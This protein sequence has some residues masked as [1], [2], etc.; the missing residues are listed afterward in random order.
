MNGG[1]PL[2]RALAKWLE[3]ALRGRETHRERA[4][5]R[6]RLDGCA[7]RWTYRHTPPVCCL[8]HCLLFNLVDFTYP[9]GLWARPCAL[10]RATRQPAAQRRSYASRPQTRSKTRLTVSSTC[11]RRVIDGHAVYESRE[12]KGAANRETVRRL[13]QVSTVSAA[14]FAEIMQGF[15]VRHN[16]TRSRAC[17]CWMSRSTSFV[18]DGSGRQMLHTKPAALTAPSLPLRPDVPLTE[19]EATQSPN[20]PENSRGRADVAAAAAPEGRGR[21]ARFSFSGAN[22]NRAPPSLRAERSGGRGGGNGSW[23][24]GRPAPDASPRRLS[25]RPAQQALSLL[26]SDW[27]P[28][29]VHPCNLS[30]LP[31]PGYASCGGK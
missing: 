11:R 20:S 2:R 28:L 17:V 14:A 7:H 5:S 21:P 30:M 22:D 1:S 6:Q 19:K 16:I 8:N 23:T 3:A 10:S 9:S 29:K 4:A 26:D 12:I 15:A 31:P 24:C 27:E 25:R 13:W 18:K